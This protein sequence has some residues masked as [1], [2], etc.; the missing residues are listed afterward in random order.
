MDALSEVKRSCTFVCQNAQHVEINN[1]A[2]QTFLEQ[3]TQQNLQKICEPQAFDRDLHFCDGG[4]LT[5][6]YL[7]VV[8]SVNFCFW[9]DQELE[10]EHLAKGFKNAVEQDPKALT[11]EKLSQFTGYQLRSILGWKSELPLEQERV[12][13][14]REVGN[15]LLEHFDGRAENLIKAC[16]GKAS[17][18]VELVTK[19]FPGFRDHCV[20]NGKQIFIYKR[21]QI[22]VGDVWGA[23]QGEGLGKFDDIDS[24]TMFADY[25]VPVVLRELGILQYSEELQRLVDG[26]QELQAGSQ[27]EV[28]I[29][30][31]SIEAIERIKQG[32]KHSFKNCVTPH[33]VQIDWWVWQV[34]EQH[35]KVHK[36]HHRVLTIYY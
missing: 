34:G 7:L 5:T 12:R 13:L 19:Y 3:L 18:L 36:P 25:R 27:M 16:K 32:L 4:P 26:M 11:A 24:L 9:P 21:A 15:V 20:Y 1:D 28:E 31:C 17:K 35:R 30:A 8:D 22:F 2:I 6:Q 10:Y 23:F 33:S 29:R 14:I